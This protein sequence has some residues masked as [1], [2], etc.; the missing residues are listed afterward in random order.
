MSITV[1]VSR[2]KKLIYTLIHFLLQ[3]TQ[4]EVVSIGRIQRSNGSLE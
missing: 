3:N 2:L 4:D 1:K